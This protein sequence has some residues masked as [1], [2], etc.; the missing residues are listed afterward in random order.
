MEKI[1]KYINKVVNKT[2][3]AIIA[4]VSQ[5]TSG[6]GTPAPIATKTVELARKVGAEGMVL[7][8]NDNQVLPLDKDTVVSVFGR[9]QQDYFY[10]GYGSGG[11]VKVPYKVNLMAGL[12]GAGIKVN[13]ELAEIY[14]KWCQDNPVDHGFWGHWPMCYDEMPIKDKDIE[15]A[16]DKSN[17]A[18][19][20]I[21][22]A[23]GED[24]ENTLTKGSY[25]LTDE[26]HR[27]L[28][29]VTAKFN[30]T[31]VLLNIGNIMDMSWIDKYNIS[32][33]LIVWQGGMESGNSIADILSGKETPSGKLTD[34]IAKCYQD[35]PSGADFGGKL[36]NN[37]VEDI[38][39][40]YRYFRTFAKDKVL[41][42]FGYGLS[43]T[44]F[45]IEATH[46]NISASSINI[47]VKV[48]NIGSYKGKEIVQ[49]Y[50]S[51]PQ[52]KLGKPVLSLAVF[53][54][55]KC[56]EP[57]QAQELDIS[58]SI[59][60]M[61]SYDDNGSTGYKSAY[62]LEKGIYS[63]LYGNSIDNLSK[64]CEYIQDNTA[65]TKQLE[66]VS[67]VQPE[68]IFNRLV[69]IT[70]GDT[71]VPKYKSVP[72][73]SV[74][75]KG[76][77]SNNLPS[78]IPLT[79]DKGIKLADVKSGKASMQDFVAQ[80]SL[81]ELEALTRGD[82]IMGSSLGAKGNAGVFGGVLASLR[83]KGIPPITTTDGPSGIRLAAC[84][85][86]LPNGTGLAS[87]WNTALITEVY[88]HIAQEMIERG[89]NVLLAPGMNIHRNVLCGRNFEYFSEDPL[90]SGVIASAVVQGLQSQG[91]SA[92][93]KH[94]ACNNQEKRRIF[95]DSRLSER[96][97]REIYLKGFEICIR[98][99]NPQN[100][101]TSY[102][103]ING[104]WGHYK[105]DLCT[106][107]LRGEWGYKGNVIT[108]WWMRSAKSPEFPMLQ[109]QAYRIR[110]QVDVL[111]PGGK[112]VGKK[113][114]DGTLL[115]SLGKDGGITLGEIQ[116][117]AINILNFALI[118]N[119]ME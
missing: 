113:R 71:I 64:C 90:V 115:K 32:S 95:N 59:A 9:V 50:Y 14:K 108:D 98:E 2:V 21:G 97:L 40:G 110:A 29:G 65:I 26:E 34:T 70:Q 81:D 80:L 33:L 114:P 27:L 109:N 62:V 79:K 77:I 92:C 52:G 73:R 91:V 6:E 69:A 15:D 103:K 106:T 61:A 99:S 104:V 86:L 68:C 10:V 72:A 25:Y 116:R 57:N 89:S 30:K 117:S 85:S 31:V 96:A 42:P 55:T 56:L 12:E 100:I 74:S 67:A 17:T 20:V 4:S 41:Y 16:L 93:P 38:Y 83:E 107:I 111:M 24:R 3:R 46:T 19:I 58:Y 47:K 76:K 13:Q 22:R 11:D 105:Y 82:Y 94:F 5:D 7:L 37:Y 23:A 35:Y 18:L 60:D 39:V 8:K 101:M 45:N 1:K 78:E 43:Y 28:K 102:N 88:Q 44:D 84:S 49:V 53:A 87:S 48:T 118:S 36:F 119:A 66:E 75:L 51:P 112:R 63:I 54:K